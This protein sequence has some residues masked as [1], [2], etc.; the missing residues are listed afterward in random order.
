MDLQL[1]FILALTFVIHLVGTLAYAFRIAGVRTGRIATAL[2]LFNVLV[3]VSRTSNSFQGPFLAKRVETDILGLVAHPLLIDFSLILGAAS[4]A[5]IAGGLLIPTMQRVAVRGV[6]RFARE[7]SVPGLVARALT[8]SGLSVL[9]RSAALP[10]LS[11]LTDLRAG[12]D[13]SWSILALNVGANALW[14]VGVLAAIYGGT[15]DPAFRVT[16]ATLSSIINGVATI[17]LFVV[18]DPY[19]AGLTDDVVRGRESEA[20][21]RRVVV[22]MVA[23]RLLGTLL[24]QALLIPYAYLIAMTARLL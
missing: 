4:L 7:R 15:I 22:W 18:I 24:A 16:A 14:T 11:N 10:R 19:L 2:S 5:T 20:R 3:L 8:P 12:R 13:V 6:D 1:A 21:F 17:A 23:S 9:A